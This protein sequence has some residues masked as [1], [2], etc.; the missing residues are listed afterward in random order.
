MTRDPASSRDPSGQIHHIN[1]KVFRSVQPVAISD[2][3]FVRDSGALAPLIGQGS[4][5]SG[6]EVN[7]SVLG[8]DAPSDGYG[9]EH[10]VIDF[11]SYPYEWSFS[12][13][14][15]TAILHLDIQIKLL[16][17]KIALSDATAYNIQFIGT[18]PVFVDFLSFRRYRE[19]EHWGAHR[20]FCDQF[21]NP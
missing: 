7:I 16:K 12:A 18:K 6:D 3:E 9:L 1:G 11:W 2:Y 4:V 17:H 10:P 20:Q 15:A 5:I 14:K 8:P 13:L 21:L 19:N